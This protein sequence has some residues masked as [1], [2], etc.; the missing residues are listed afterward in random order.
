MVLVLLSLICLSEA[1]GIDICTQ[2]KYV[3]AD[4]LLNVPLQVL[5]KDISLL[6]MGCNQNLDIA[7]DVGYFAGMVARSYGFN[8]VAFGTLDT[9]DELDPNPVDRI[10]RSPYITAQVI[11]YLA[12]GFVNSGVIPV[13]NATGNI[14]AEVVRALVNRKAIYP[15]LVESENKIQKLIDLGY[16]TVFVL[17]DGSVKGKLPNLRIDTKVNL[18]EIEQIRKKVLEGAIVLLS[19]SEEIINV[20]QPFSKTGVLVFSN[21]EWLLE[22][23]KEVIRGSRIPT[24][25]AP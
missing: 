18:S 14:D 17:V 7:R 20:N 24:G 8:Y 2:L 11:T 6:S 25:R 23:A 16:E 13:V 15:S 4:C 5:L 9:L 22:Q 19:R 21:E 10:S 3:H 1:F 12:E